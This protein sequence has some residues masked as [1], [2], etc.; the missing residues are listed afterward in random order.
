MVFAPVFENIAKTLTE[1]VEEQA[2]GTKLVLFVKINV[3]DNPVIADQFQ[4]KSIPTAAVFKN[5]ELMERG[6][7]GREGLEVID[8]L[9]KNLSP[10]AG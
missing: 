2:P 10:S 4:V 3:D 7:G 1:E 6:I 5:G 8:N 9:V